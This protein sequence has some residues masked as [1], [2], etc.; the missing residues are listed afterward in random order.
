MTKEYK[1]VDA[2]QTVFKGNEVFA[3]TEKR[4]WGGAR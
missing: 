4:N 1:K 3:K 2:A